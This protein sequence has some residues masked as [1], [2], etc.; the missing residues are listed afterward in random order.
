MKSALIQRC[1]WAL[2]PDKV[3]WRGKGIFHR[4]LGENGTFLDRV[5]QINGKNGVQENIQR[6]TNICYYL[7]VESKKSD[8]RELVYK[9]ETDLQI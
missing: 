4:L 7:F 3:G 8:T 6:K 2:H 1:I 5:G 9:T